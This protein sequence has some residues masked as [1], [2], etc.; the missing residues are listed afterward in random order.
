MK[1]V[2]VA[3]GTGSIALQ[4]GLYDVFRKLDGIDVKI[5]VN[6]YDNGKST[7]DV[8]R[9]ANGKILGPSDVRKNQTTRLSLENPT[10]PLLRLLEIR[11]TEET[12]EAQEFCLYALDQ[13]TFARVEHKQTLI[14][15]INTYFKLPF[16]TKIDYNDFSLAN[17]I[18]A[19]LAVQHK[20]SLRAAATIM[21][22]VMGIADNVIL[23]DDTS[24][25]LGAITKSG[26]K[27][28]DE[29]DIVSWGKVDDPFVHIFFTTADGSE[30]YPKLCEEADIALREADLIILSSGTQWSSLIPTYRS[31]GFKSAID[32][33]AAK[34]I[35]VMNRQP[36]TDSPGQSASDIIRL[37]V[38]KYFNKKQLN[39]VVD[40][41]TKYQQMSDIDEDALSLI[42]KRF[43]YDMSSEF[44]EMHSKVHN[45]EK[46]ADAVA[47]TY[48]DTK[49]KS[50]HFMFDYDDT[51]VG[52]G[53]RLPKSSKSNIECLGM[54]NGNSANKFSV[55]TGN[56]VKALN[57]HAFT[58][59]RSVRKPVQVFA[60]GGINEYSY[61][62][63]F[64]DAQTAEFVKCLNPDV[65]ITDRDV[66]EIRLKLH[67]G[68]IPLSKV[69]N[70]GNAMISIKPIAEEY[71]DSITLLIAYLIKGSGFIVR[72]AGRTTIE[73]CNPN[74]SKA[75]A[76]NYV[77]SDKNTRVT[78]I[79]DELHHGGNDEPIYDIALN[80]VDRVKCLK[81]NSPAQT[82]FFLKTLVKLSGK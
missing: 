15:A 52:R 79:G 37:L 56:S 48:F 6:A 55:C 42:D 65:A 47:L 39:V 58:D 69:E 24:L 2:I 62:K 17:I 49:L 72:P 10:S 16:A 8:R 73:I 23:N 28:T 11:F 50:N 19:G 40:S 43:G 30:S 4:S 7:G 12:S 25:F 14:D 35:M 27:V 41:S 63:K 20:N 38:P 44:G 54:L 67:M 21:A 1:I 59:G 51:L 57:L 22:D 60:D 81:V 32:N 80:N 71:R 64:D 66:E 82:A 78:Y 36:D 45:P 61:I 68:S 75:T 77:L 26:I 31:I 5:L 13:T 74:L 46:L 18:Y 34:I 53:N 29:G 9:V 76:L 33:T 70:R 3:G